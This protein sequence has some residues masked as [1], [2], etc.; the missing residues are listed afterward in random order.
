VT[1]NIAG[2]FVKAVKNKYTSAGF[3]REQRRKER[4]AENRH[5]ET[6]KK[7]LASQLDSLR[8]TYEQQRNS[9]IRELTADDDQITLTAIQAL[10]SELTGYFKLKKLNPDTLSVADY[11]KEPILRAYVIDKIQQQNADFFADLEPLHQQIELL[12]KQVKQ[13]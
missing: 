4:L 11:R 12:E 2:F 8:D 1:D 6:L 9:L 7:Q 3:E 13:L 5:R 10:K